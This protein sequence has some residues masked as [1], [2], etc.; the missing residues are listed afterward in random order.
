MVG[1]EEYVGEELGAGR[2]GA[3]AS[4][5]RQVQIVQTLRV[6]PKRAVVEGEREVWCL[7]LG[8]STGRL[9]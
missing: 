9:T 5:Q 8:E 2:V 3:R 4:G 6:R 1:S 7:S